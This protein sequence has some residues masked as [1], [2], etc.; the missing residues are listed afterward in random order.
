MPVN[1]SPESS[2]PVCRTAYMSIICTT[3]LGLCNFGGLSDDVDVSSTDM[4]TK[5]HE[6]ARLRLLL[7]ADSGNEMSR[8]NP[9]RH[10]VLTVADTPASTI[11]P[12]R[13]VR[14]AGLRPDSVTTFSY[15]E[16]I[17]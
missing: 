17:T 4:T 2:L 11:Y 9:A 12:K 8:Y 13:W 5:D 15:R 14:R 6:I 10:C 1:G 16:L 3:S 7:A